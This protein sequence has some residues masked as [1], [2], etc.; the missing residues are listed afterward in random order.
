M[1][2]IPDTYSGDHQCSG[3]RDSDCEG[4][5]QQ[6]CVCSQHSQA[7][8]EAL[9]PCSNIN[10]QIQNADNNMIC[11]PSWL[12]G[13]GTLYNIGCQSQ[14]AYD[15]KCMAT[16]CLQ[17]IRQPKRHNEQDDHPSPYQTAYEKQEGLLELPGHPVKELKEIKPYWPVSIRLCSPSGVIQQCFDLVVTHGVVDDDL[18]NVNFCEFKHDIVWMRDVKQQAALP[19]VLLNLSAGALG[20]LHVP[21]YVEQGAQF[22]AYNTDCS[23][24][25]LWLDVCQVRTVAKFELF[26]VTLNLLSSKQDALLGP[27]MHCGELQ[28]LCMI[29]VKLESMKRMLFAQQMQ[30]TNEWGSTMSLSS[31]MHKTYRHPHWSH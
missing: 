8:C 12:R 17:L 13:T 11:M 10:C 16:N 4:C 15:D 5:H 29:K 18:H 23:S 14:H 3:L 28:D 19:S 9:K 26:L 22:A 24:Q 1:R 31:L 6:G 2:D 7:G 27:T 21:L 30:L 20:A 25:Q